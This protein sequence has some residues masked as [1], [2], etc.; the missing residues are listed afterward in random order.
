MAQEIQGPSADI[1]ANDYVVVQFDLELDLAMLGSTVVNALRQPDVTYE[2][3]GTTA[4]DTPWGRKSL[5]FAQSGRL[6]VQH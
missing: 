2:F 5:N 6:Q 1:P 4:F 3:D